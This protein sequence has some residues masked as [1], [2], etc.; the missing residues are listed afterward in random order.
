MKNILNVVL[1]LFVLAQ[2]LR[3][4]V[5]KVASDLKPGVLKASATLAG[6]PQP[7]SFN[8]TSTIK[9]ENGA[10]TITDVTETT[11][12]R[13]TETVTVEKGTLIVRKRVIDNG[14]RIRYEVAGNKAT[15][16]IE[17][18]GRQIPIS[19]SLESPL[20]A[21]GASA[22]HSIAVLPLA[23]GYKATYYN[24]DPGTQRMLR[25]Q[26][27][28]V[29]SE[30]VTVPAGSFDAFKIE[31]QAEGSTTQSTL[32]VAKQTRKPVK[33]FSHLRN[34]LTLTMESLP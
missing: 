8:L 11:S 3:A 26:L 24:F 28:V 30:K 34:G 31:Y 22:A 33:G 5:P 7:I 17:A 25:V 19:V 21:E 32:W 1:L 2:T 18:A 15:G 10:W 6:G 20:F 29:G 27:R 23:E 4:Q 16:M 12:G 13:T 14:S 9:E